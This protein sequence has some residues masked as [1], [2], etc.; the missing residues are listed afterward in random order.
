MFKDNVLDPEY[1]A[2][3]YWV[4]KF[5]NKTLDIVV[6]RKSGLTIIELEPGM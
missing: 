5:L 1:S 2:Q 3:R 4:S 6:I